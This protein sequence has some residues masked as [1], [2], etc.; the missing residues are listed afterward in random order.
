MNHRA[1]PARA[2]LPCMSLLRNL[3]INVDMGLNTRSLIVRALAARKHG[4]G[5]QNSAG[6]GASEMMNSQ[7]P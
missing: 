1:G 5:R 7:H 3:P 2:S 6:R 4:L